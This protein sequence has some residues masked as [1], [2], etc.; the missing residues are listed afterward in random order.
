MNARIRLLMLVLV[1]ALTAVFQAVPAVVSAQSGSYLD[2]LY[3]A[4]E[5]GQNKESGTVTELDQTGDSQAVGVQ[6]SGDEAAPVYFRQCQLSASQVESLIKSIIQQI[7]SKYGAGLGGRVIIIRIPK[8]GTTQPTTPTS[9]S[10]KPTTTT[11]TATPG[12]TAA[13]TSSTAG[14]K[15]EIKSKYGISANDGD[16]ATWSQKQLE[17]ANKVLATLPEAF[18]SHTKTLQRDAVFQNPGVYGYVRLGIPT[19]HL[20]N[21]ACYQGT[22]QGTLV[23]EMT[24]TLQANK[25][26]LVRA[27]EQ[28]FWASG[29]PNPGS[30][31]T[32]GNSQPIEDFAESVRQYWQ[33]GAS[34]KKSQPARYEFVRKYVMGG[35][36]Y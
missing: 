8:T 24:H 6:Q 20:L 25:P 2:T 22:F 30:V 9:T 23:H 18:R 36:E 32:Y 34:M 7:L 4:S 15:A 21:A 10:T 11:T 16:G 3:Q 19:V 29:R 31:S 12:T 33:A 1:F 26:Q 17:E 35:K 27:W 28:Q 14:L 5:S 13:N